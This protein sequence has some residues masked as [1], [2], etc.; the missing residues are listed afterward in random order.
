MPVSLD[1]SATL[2][3][4]L[5]DERD[6]LSVRMAEAVLQV[7][8]VVP[9]LWRLE[10]RNALL[11]GERRGRL[12]ASDVSAMLEDVAALPIEVVWEHAQGGDEAELAL[13]RTHGLSVYDAAYLELAR[14]RSLPL[15]TR[16]DALGAAA[17]SIGLR[18]RPSR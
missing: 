5:Q 3:W 8:A 4:L 15:M 9:P 14:R 7:G 13:A 18:W 12:K 2:S 16:D 1:A 17:G 10:L 6:D 11:A